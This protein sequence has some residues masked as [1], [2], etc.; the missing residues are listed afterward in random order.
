MSSKLFKAYYNSPLGIL[1]LISDKDALRALS[2]KE[3]AGES[4]D[5]LPIL[6]ETIKELDSY[7]KG[8][9]KQFSIPLKP[10]GTPFQKQVWQALRQI[11]YGETRSYGEV[12]QMIS[13]PQASRAV[14]GANNRN[15]LA[16]VI[17]C[18]RIVGSKGALT[19]YAGELWRKEWL[20]KHEQGYFQG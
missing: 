19:G 12:A 20:L 6:N 8:K 16:I 15:R 9:L 1:E 10:D 4:N 5:S 13:K 11:P 7:F 17:P 2:F 18:H 14:G 3:I